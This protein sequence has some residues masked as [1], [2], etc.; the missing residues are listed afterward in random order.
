MALLS[1]SSSSGASIWLGA[2]ALLACAGCVL[3]DALSGDST[4]ALVFSHR[5]H[6]L[7]EELDCVS[8][9]ESASVADD[10]GMPV[11][12]ACSV[13]HETMDEEKPPE[14]RIATLFDDSGNF[15]AARASALEDEVVFAHLDH[16]R[17]VVVCGACH[18]DIE[19][20]RAIDEDVAVNM[21]DCMSCHMERA[22]PNECATCHTAVGRDLPPASHV[23]EWQR[24]HGRASRLPAP[25]PADRCFLCHEE[26]T[27]AACHQLE[28]PQ[29]HNANFRLRG[30]AILARAD[31]ATCAACHESFSCDR[32][33]MEVLPLS[34]TPLWGSRR[35]T[36]CLTCHFPLLSSGCET[37]HKGTPSHL[38]G[39]PKPA[40]HNPAMNC[41]QCH[42]PTLPLSHVDN[43]SNCNLCHP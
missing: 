21:D 2:C 30:H 38:L 29:N 25:E 26:S 41:R 42:G 1:R 20:S 40:W 37:C 19:K 43:G 33:H 15:R 17:S 32:C 22:I 6:V 18:T 36:H 8:C 10:P 23:H 16:V 7:E 24:R 3:F 4:A 28:P 14:R 31:R 9:H 13:C 34:H 11:F 5:L 39:P 12:D 27:C 35:N